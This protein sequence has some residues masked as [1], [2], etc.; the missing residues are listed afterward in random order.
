MQAII[1]AAG[2]G[3]R[4]W[5]LS[6]NKPKPL[7]TLFGISILEHNLNQLE[8]LVDEAFIIVG[9]KKEMIMEKIGEKWGKIKIQYVEQEEVD[10]TGRAAKL[11]L[12]FIKGDFVLLNGDDFY[13]KDDIKK[14]IDLSPSILVKEHK[15]PCAFGVVIT[16]EN[17]AKSIVEKP[18]E[19]ISNLV[20]AALYCL[21]KSIFDFGI[22][23]SP[24]GEYEF[25]DYVTRFIH[26]DTLH[27]SKAEFWCP[28][29]YPWDLFAAIPELFKMEKKRNRGKVE[30][31][32]TLKG[33]VIIE[34]GSIIKSGA[35]IE[36]PVYIGKNCV[37][38]P[39]CFLRG[40]AIIEDECVIGNSVEVKNSIVG[41]GTHIA[42]L[43]YVGD[44]IVGENC[45]FGA[46]TIIA[47][48]RH[49]GKNIKTKV[50]DEIVDTHLKKF[51]AIFGDGV[52]TGIGTLV[53]PGKKIWPGKMTMPGEKVDNDII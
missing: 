14:A 51:G 49:D 16:E 28:A 53:Y 38:G 5:P 52:K 29:S 32:A 15:N 11:A 36:G 9:Y 40:G 42:H 31:G 19:P 6:I 25:T 20:N 30:K 13:F 7:F 44:S 26:G 1:L 47:N 45:N 21:P 41:K 37:I 27:A 12:P 34:E 50:K 2:K 24:R 33:D 22:D 39:N 35:Y 18:S 3:T 23:R 43:S 48:L 17:F 46:G 4:F 8:G 10:G